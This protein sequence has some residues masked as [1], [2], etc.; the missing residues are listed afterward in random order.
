MN[1]T[2]L[3]END[4]ANYRQYNKLTYKKLHVRLQCY[5]SKFALNDCFED[6][7]ELAKQGV[8]CVS[9]TLHTYE[10]MNG[11]TM[12]W[13]DF[14]LRIVNREDMREIRKRDYMVNNQNYHAHFFFEI[15]VVAQ[16]TEKQV[17]KWQDWCLKKLLQQCEI[18]KKKAK[19]WLLQKEMQA[20]FE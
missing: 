5:A 14:D 13:K 1:I 3:T 12:S 7:N 2:E 15:P 20:D 16:F 4:I 10:N 8:Y 6:M 18:N 19:Q 9:M 17:D 11:E